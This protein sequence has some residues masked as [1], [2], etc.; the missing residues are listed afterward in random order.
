MMVVTPIRT[1]ITLSIEQLY[2]QIVCH[3]HNSKIRVTKTCYPDK[4]KLRGAICQS[5]VTNLGDL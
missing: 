2:G 5:K 4:V 3:Y 1:I